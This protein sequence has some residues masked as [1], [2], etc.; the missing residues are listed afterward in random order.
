MLELGPDGHGKAIPHFQLLSRKEAA[1]YLGITEGTLAVW[2]CTKRYPIPYVKIGRLAKY[3]V[4]DLDAFIE[5][6]LKT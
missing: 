5:S 2:N 1:A 4:A 6:R 3:R